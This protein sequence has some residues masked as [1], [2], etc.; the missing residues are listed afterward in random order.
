M[1]TKLLILLVA[2]LVL[3]AAVP[4]Y[5]QATKFRS[6]AVSNALTVSGA[7]GLN[8]LTTSGAAT[9]GGALGVTGNS[10][11]AGTLQYGADNLYPLGYGS[12]SQQVVCGTTAEFTGTLQV[13]P[14]GLT[15]VIYVIPAQ[16]TT[17]ITTAALLTVSDPTTSTFT[18]LSW[19]SDYTEGT[20]GIVAHYCAVGAQ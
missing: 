2:V 6:I 7:T 14:T 17:P 10:D 16:V 13:T 9:V 19:E 8:T 1:K 15:T 11:L 4:A 5:Q 18:L 3:I 12:V 20:T